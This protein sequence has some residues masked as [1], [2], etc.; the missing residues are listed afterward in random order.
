MQPEKN[1][2]SDKLGLNMS[3]LVIYT[4]RKVYNH[5]IFKSK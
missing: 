2:T 5:K 1:E 4:L 3:K